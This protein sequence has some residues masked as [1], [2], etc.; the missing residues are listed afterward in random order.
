MTVPYKVAII[1][2]TK[3]RP[4][5]LAR[6][7]ESMRRQSFQDFRIY[8]INDGGDADEVARIAAQFG[9]YEEDRVVHVDL[10]VSGGRG[11]AMSIGL[12]LVKEAYVHIHDDDD[13]LEPEFYARTVAYL[14]DDVAG[15]FVGVTTS[16]YDIV[17]HMEDG[18]I[19]FD[20]RFDVY[21]RKEGTIVDYSLFL[22]HVSLLSTITTLFRR[23]AVAGSH[24]VDTTLPYVEDQDFFQRLMMAG[25]VGII[26]DFLANY[27]QR[28][29]VTGG[30]EDKSE[31]DFKYDAVMAYTNN[32]VREAIRGR[33][34]M[35][36]LQAAFI[37][38]SR[39][40]HRYAAPLSHQ[41]SQLQQQ[42]G[43]LSQEVS[44]LK[45]DIGRLARL[46]SRL[47]DRLE[48]N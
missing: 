13:T 8:I 27:H 14:D 39:Q 35:R 23:S 43:Q 34:K 28:P 7:L 24:G 37:Q 29:F 38:N 15:T 48:K 16:S 19:V 18:R 9:P 25:E 6:A 33:G 40:G 10:P 2:R 20:N 44:S 11:Q 42:C 26:P 12:G 47:A 4:L 21:G 5:F 17:E 30:P 41:V 36:E 1:L 32:V 45:D 22:S 3:N 31:T 46:V